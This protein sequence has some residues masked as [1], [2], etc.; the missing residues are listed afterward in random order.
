MRFGFI[1]IEILELKV[2]TSF[3]GSE[4]YGTLNFYKISSFGI[5]VLKACTFP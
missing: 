2:Q 5:N 1:G 4:L 3:K